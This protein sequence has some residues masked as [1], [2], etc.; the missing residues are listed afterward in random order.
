MEDNNIMENE[1]EN[2]NTEVLCVSEETE[3]NESGSA[4]KVAVG[5]GVATLVGGVLYKCVAKPLITK[6]KAKKEKERELH[7]YAEKLRHLNVY[8]DEETKDVED[9]EMTESE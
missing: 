4:M 6:W 3:T 2:E 5:L 8:N 9:D 7:E 1:N